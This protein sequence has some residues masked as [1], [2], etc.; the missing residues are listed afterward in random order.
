VRGVLA[1]EVVVVG[2]LDLDEGGLAEE[3]REDAAGVE[4]EADALGLGGGEE[5][6]ASAE[7]LDVAVCE[8]KLADE[9]FERGG[10]FAQDEGDVV[11]D[12]E[13]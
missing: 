12:C 8:V 10:V 3:A 13:G 6:G 1:G 9:L 11:M 4:G 5:E 7:A 2:L